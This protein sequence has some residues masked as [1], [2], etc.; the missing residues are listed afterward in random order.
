MLETRDLYLNPVQNGGQPKS[1]SDFDKLPFF[2]RRPCKTV[3]LTADDI[4]I[5]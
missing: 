5:V 4:V 3:A 1:L 2:T